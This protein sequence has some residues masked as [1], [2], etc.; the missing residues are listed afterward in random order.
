MPVCRATSRGGSIAEMADAGCTKCHDTTH[1]FEADWFNLQSPELSRILRA[2]LPAGADEHGLGLCRQRKIDT[3]FR[4]L[5]IMSTGRYQHAVMPLDAFPAQQWREWDASGD[6]VAS[7]ASAA[8][9][10]Y[11]KMLQ[12]IRGARARA[13]ASP[14]VDMP[15]AMPL[16]GES[17]NIYPVP[18]PTPE[19][20]SPLAAKQLPSGEIELTWP[21][22]RSAGTERIADGP[23]RQHENQIPRLL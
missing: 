21:R 10:T 19:R 17:R 4:R 12:I 3:D 22:D 14:R 7:F 5:R 13:M 15:G 11:Q 23:Q 2:P 6:V 16:A 18:I 1:R 8:D 20:L 9:P